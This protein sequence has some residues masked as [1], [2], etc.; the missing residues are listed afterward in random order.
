MQ[1]LIEDRPPADEFKN[2]SPD[3]VKLLASMRLQHFI[4]RILLFKR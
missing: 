3:E 4:K 1:R 2:D